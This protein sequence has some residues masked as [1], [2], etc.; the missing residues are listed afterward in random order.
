MKNYRGIFLRRA[1]LLA[2]A[3]L[4]IL[5]V[6]SQTI[7]LWHTSGS[8]SERLEYSTE[9]FGTSSGTSTITIDESS[10]YQTIDGFGYT[11]TQASAKVISEMSATER[12]SLLNVI[13]GSEGLDINIVRLG[14]GATDLGDYAYS[15]HDDESGSFSL[16]G[17]DMT[18][19]IPILQE[20]LAIDPDIKIL[21]TPWSAPAWMKT[22]NSLRGGELDLAHYADYAQYW[23]N[24][25]NAMRNLGI[26][27]WAVTP[28]NEPENAHN[29]PSMVFTK[30]T[31]L[32]F[33][34]NHMGPAL[35][36][37][38]FNCKILAFDH[39]CDNADFPTHVASNS[40]YVDGSA[41][42]LY[43]GGA[44]ISAM[45]TVYNATGKD[46][47]FTEQYTGA[48]M[49]FSGDLAWHT[50][51]VMI[52][53]LNNYSKIAL[54]WNLATDPNSGP[55]I[56][57]TC[58]TCQG[59]ITLDGDNATKN[60]S[61]YIAGQ[62][63][64]VIK[65]DAVRIGSTGD[66]TNLVHTAAINPDGSIALVVLNKGG[67]P[68]TFN[69]DYNDAIFD[70]TLAGGDV[71]SFKLSFREPVD[72][73]GVSV[74]PTSLNLI[75]GET[76]DLT[77]TVTPDSSTNKSVRWSSSNTN[78]AT[79]SSSGLVTGIG[80]GSAII[81]VTT[82]D[83]GFSAISSVNV[84]TIDVTGVS[85]SP[86]SATIM[87]RRTLS[88]AETVSPTNASNQSVI[89]S[90]S[91]TSVA[92]V[93][94]NGLVKGTGEGTAIITVTTED[95]EYTATSSITVTPA[96]NT[97]FIHA[98]GTKII[99][100][101]GEEIFFTGMNLGNWLVWE[102]YLMMNEFV[103]QTHTQYLNNLKDA[104]GEEKA[105]E[106]LHE[107]RL[108]YVTEQS[109]SELKGLGI[110]SVRV[111]FHYNMFWDDEAGVEID[112]GFQY[113]DSLITWCTKHEV[114]ILLDM[115]A[116]PGYQNIGDHGDNMDVVPNAVDNN[117]PEN[118][119]TVKFWDNDGY[120]IDIAA[121]VWKH[122]A[123]RY[124]DES[125]IWGYGLLNE[126]TQV[127]GR[128]DELL[129]SMV[130]MTKAIREVDANHTIVPTGAWWGSQMQF[131]DWTD[132]TMQ[133]ASGISERWDDNLVFETHHYVFGNTEWLPDLYERPDLTNKLDV[134]LIL[135]EYGE[136]TE[137]ILKTM[138]DWSI[139]N[140]SGYFPWSFKKMFMDKCLWTIKGNDTYLSLI[141]YI[142][143]GGTAPNFD[144]LMLFV[145]NEI[146][147]GSSS[148][149]WNQ[150][151]Y[152]A[153]KRDCDV[154]SPSNLTAS[155]ITTSSVTIN[156]NDASN[157][158]GYTVS[159]S[160][161]QSETISANT[162]SYT[163]SGL[164]E[165][166]SYTFNVTA[167]SDDCVGDPIEINAKTD[168]GGNQTP[169]SGSA[170]ELPGTI[171]GEDFDIGCNAYLD[172]SEGNI[173]GLYRE[174]DVDITEGA[175]DGYAIGWIDEGEWLEYTVNVQKSGTYNLDYV[176]ASPDGTGE[177][178]LQVDS[179][180]LVTMAAPNTGDWGAY[181]TATAKVSLTAGIQK[182][183]L[184][185]SGALN[186]DKLIFIEDTPRYLNRIVI[187]PSTTYIYEGDIVDFNATGYDQFNEEYTISE[188]WTVSEGS[189]D[190]DGVFAG[191]ALG[192]YIVTASADTIS[193]TATVEVVEEPECTPTVPGVYQAE[194]FTAM[195]GIQT[196]NTED[197]DGGFNVGW[198]DEGD[199][200]EYGE[201]CV[202][203]DT[204]YKFEFRVASKD[205][206][207]QFQVQDQ[208]ANVLATIDVPVT[209]DWQN[210]ETVE[211]IVYLTKDVT[212]LRLVVT[213]GGFNINW[214]E[215]SEYGG[216]DDILVTGVTL[217]ESSLDLIIDE[218]AS[219]VKTISPVDAT[220]Q[221]VVWAS[222]NE[223]VATV[224]AQGVVTAVNTGNAVVSVT[225]NDGSFVAEC[226]V[227]VATEI[228][229]P[230][231]ILIQAEDYF[232]MNGIQTENTTDT[233][234]GLNVGWT[235]GGDWMGYAVE[236]PSSGTYTVE[237]RV[238]SLNGG[239][240]LKLE[241]FGGSES[242]GTLSIPST[243][244]WQ[245]WT[246]ISHGVNLE[247]GEQDI[248]VAVIDGGWNIN[249]LK[250]TKGTLKSAGDEMNEVA[251]SELT[252]Y[253]NPVKSELYIQ[254]ISDEVNMAIYSASGAK[255][256]ESVGYSIN[257]EH[258]N[259]G[260]Y[261][262]RI[263]NNGTIEQHK[264]MKVK[265]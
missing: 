191:N 118:R 24:Y 169:F 15:Y 224:S 194:A 240:T 126:P 190:G 46:V 19:T 143:Y 23:V 63:S 11:L 157:E 112:H 6:E 142:N 33:V 182:I 213:E 212:T 121:K 234:G 170:L 84:E 22:N 134:P 43:D 197:T 263:Q 133:A 18:Y 132:S 156:W 232:Q 230:V 236:I 85:V 115:H 250:I 83:G 47:Y 160:D 144:E 55:F 123:A 130:E 150:G 159:C 54:E 147:N 242:Y 265:N 138:T 41:F 248:A 206:G 104:Y 223:F 185:F 176:V 256:L 32:D 35:R 98:E 238:A 42:H 217:S 3:V 136:D 155:E 37:A 120:Y 218:T 56:P 109:I 149:T 102:G 200:L 220:D 233:D 177:I 114:Y 163:F 101:N 264:F 257:V 262:I 103:Y 180:T 260:V 90:S 129:S 99:D 97:P 139:E 111:P 145:K 245:N 48:G 183:R 235:D 231:S 239:G 73:E 106:F 247:A 141:N 81:T 12:S 154:D 172:F 173:G 181:D 148:L 228:D 110:N 10:T 184:V 2:T 211:G 128:E 59:A 210:W 116:A 65:K 137:E 4:S 189:I 259:A 162:T 30:E 253:P 89:W 20:I 26:E 74:S 187:S 255:I 203:S 202:N 192:E 70:Y 100:S 108:N 49:S 124:K 261:F 60:V 178:Q 86:T 7:D 229:N 209:G 79:V 95:G 94:S 77:E 131:L 21:A 199:W 29:T 105:L 237:Y 254:G 69:V 221:T 127:E 119:A 96:I 241:T 45:S 252:V 171:E 161:G 34:N 196:E 249:W 122:I 175:N 72:V 125:I 216:E 38:N 14:I 50:E 58:E 44:N 135:G 227:T 151:F 140:T 1:L 92:T 8:G 117:T 80:K 186:F 51:K 167:Y 158:A 91:N 36:E 53:S 198:I 244:G 207:G 146:Q 168:C 75:A 174:G 82:V 205:N 39:N 166:T 225:T 57:G 40:S 78:V 222:S 164:S 93:S 243:G 52:G 251:V 28:Q 215:S 25:M 188:T 17:P 153:I 62:M 67:A 27:I 195:S 179:E 204:N 107:W 9:S 113:F 31:E 258:L 219:L 152:D 87:E 88:L 76:S 16:D 201:I 193:A 68:T 13:Y 64:K 165:F 66:N 226:N 5:M 214:F 71:V 208:N 246:T 61:Y